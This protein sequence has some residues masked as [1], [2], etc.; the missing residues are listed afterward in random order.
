MLKIATYNLRNLFD[1]GMRVSYGKETS[2]PK[3]FIDG[4]IN[5]LAGVIA[6]INPDILV[7]QEVGSEL[8]FKRIAEKV[9][10]EFITFHAPVDARGIGNAAMTKVSAQMSSTI[11]VTAFPVFVEGSVDAI[12]SDVVSSR[13]FLTMETVYDDRPLYIYALHLKA[14]TGYPMRKTKGGERIPPQNQHEESD[15]I[16]RSSVLRLIQARR[17]REIVDAHFRVDQNAQI[18]V[19]GDFNNPERSDVLNTITSSD[20]YPE[21][22]L[23]NLSETIPKEMRYSFIYHGEKMLFDHILISKNLS[24][25]VLSF[26][27]L[28]KNLKDQSQQAETE[29]YSSDHAPVVL[30]LK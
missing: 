7:A 30:T 23:I 29:Y 20:H 24:S 25:K 2:F 9:S 21:T 22:Q 19:L 1:E 17:L 13:Q 5:E 11:D 6:G 18:I 16:I 4:V 14:L 26:E 12:G 3:V 28:N 27:I 10:P 8:S 15:A